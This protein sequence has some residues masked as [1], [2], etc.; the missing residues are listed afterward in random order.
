[1]SEAAKWRDA[2]RSADSL[3][4][5][6][7]YAKAA[8]L[9]AQQEAVWAGERV[10]EPDSKIT[11]NSGG[12]TQRTGADVHLENTQLDE[13]LAELDSLVGLTPVKDQVG[14]LVNFLRVQQARKDRGFEEVDVTQHVVF[15]GNPGTGKTTV[16]RIL[17]QMFRA[18][19]LLQKG[20]LVETDRAGLVAEYLGQTAVKTNAIVDQALDGVLFID[21]AYTLSRSEFG[22][23][24][25]RE[26]IDT[27]LKRMEDNR[28]RLVVI[29]AG[30][31]DL[32]RGFVESNPGLRSR[33]SRFIDFPDYSTEELV[34]IIV[35]MAQQSDYVLASGCLDRLTAYLTAIPRDDGFGNARLARNLFEA[36]LQAQGMRLETD[37]SL[38]DDELT[39]LF[40]E[41]F[42][43]AEKLVNLI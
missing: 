34:E 23:D 26:A 36:A 37:P 17:G 28:D 8:R 42:E 38:D 30:Y 29:V 4:D 10:V 5:A 18:M 11:G 25:G 1:L 7:L 31:P 16:A 3:G 41:D 19:G 21:E 9:I 14:R 33:F 27:L 40:P 22:S 24:F 15:V 20:Q 12:A 6:L 32:M 13:L 43:H 2:V 39:Q 35:R